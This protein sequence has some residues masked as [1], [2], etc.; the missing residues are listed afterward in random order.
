MR[1]VNGILV[2]V[3]VATAVVSQQ[4]A[5]PTLPMALAK[6]QGN[7]FAGAAK[8]LETIVEREPQNGRAWRNLG[9]AYQQLK[10]ADRAV[11][12]YQQALKVQPAMIAPVYNIA[13][14]YASKGD[15]DRAFEWL[16]KAKATRK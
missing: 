15:A 3:F 8:M 6:M 12:A 2:F 4:P 9:L 1:L 14:V 5:E 13:G 16:G 7:D 11:D 10:D